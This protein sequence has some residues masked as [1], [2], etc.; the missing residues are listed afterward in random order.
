MSLLNEALRKKAGE[1][2]GSATGPRAVAVANHNPSPA[3]KSMR[4]LAVVC[5]VACSVLASWL[6]H[7]ATPVDKANGAFHQE[8]ASSASTTTKQA[9]PA[10]TSSATAND[11]VTTAAPPSAVPK[12][13]ILTAAVADIHSSMVPADGAVKKTHT[14]QSERKHPIVATMPNTG[15]TAPPAAQAP[16]RTG[17]SAEQFRLARPYWEKALSYHREG[18]FPQAIAMYSEVLRKAPGHEETLLNLSA[19]Y[20]ETHAFSKAYPLLQNLATRFPQNSSVW[21][22][23]AI[24]EIGMEKPAA[25]LTDLQRAEQAG[26]ESFDIF[27]HRGAALSQLERTDE[28]IAS[29]KQAELIKSNDPA[30]TFNLALV[31]DR[32]G[33]FIEALGYYQ[34]F[35]GLSNPGVAAQKKQVAERIAVLRN[36]LATGNRTN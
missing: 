2:N 20:I 14:K 18:Q 10:E 22:N 36:Y 3:G 34:H 12:D 4:L 25:A 7:S 33:N 15:G 31:H 17:P 32:R 19:V 27:L 26:G 21:L 16:Y 29:Y 24:A 11:S 30:L 8:P 13:P 1:K 9:V 28:A 6:W 23:L 5:A 35:L